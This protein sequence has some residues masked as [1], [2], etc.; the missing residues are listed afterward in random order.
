MNRDIINTYLLNI[1]GFDLNINLND[2][3]IIYNVRSL[4]S[5]RSNKFI[6]SDLINF[7]IKVNN[8]RTYKKEI[9]IKLE[10]ISSKHKITLSI[11]RKDDSLF[12]EYYINSLPS[13]FPEYTIKGKSPYLGDYYFTSLVT[14]PLYYIF[15]MN[16]DGEI[17]FYKGTN[18]RPALFKK[19]INGSKIRYI[20]TE[21]T[22]N[23]IKKEPL[24][25]SPLTADIVLLN[26]NYQE[27]DRINSII[28]GAQPDPHDV[29]Y[30]NDRH[31]II[32]VYE[33]K[34]VYN[35]PS[36]FHIKNNQSDIIASCIYEY[37]NNNILWKWDS[38]DFPELYILSEEGN[39]YENK[40]S[41]YADYAHINSIDVDKSDNNILI[42]LRNLSTILKINRR[43]GEIM[44]YLG[45]KKDEFNLKEEEKFS[46]QNNATFLKDGSILIFDNGVKNSKSRIVKIKIDENNKK[47][48]SYDSFNLEDRYSII[49]G[50]S[51]LLDRHKDVYLICWGGMIDGNTTVTEHDF[52]NNKTL[53]EFTYKNKSKNLGP[54]MYRAYKCI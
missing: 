40:E 13:D 34:T 53:F 32:E 30:I 35:I 12:T 2:N 50:S 14:K 39:D 21:C 27:I 36:K 11:K 51:Q 45:G 7:D 44:W 19:V 43:S 41:L 37:K 42:S 31:Y 16:N 8:I 3:S 5:D 28:N 1:N 54:I 48:I 23:P 49:M 24:K 46:K 15:K 22:N 33:P 20:Y 17:L 9:N 52:K 29:Y 6:F 38:S 10:R 25:S 18:Y 26:E 4:N 47:I